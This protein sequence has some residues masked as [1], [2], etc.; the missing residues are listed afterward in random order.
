M[1]ST[2]HVNLRCS[3]VHGKIRNVENKLCR[4]ILQA[5]RLHSVGVG[6]TY[7]MFLPCKFSADRQQTSYIEEES[8]KPAKNTYPKTVGASSQKSNSSV[9]MKKRDAKTSSYVRKWRISVRLLGAAR[10]AK[11][12][13]SRV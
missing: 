13:V 3:T 6:Y 1:N 5:L 2:C 11:S 9:A 12:L 7:I 8:A 10:G 4:I